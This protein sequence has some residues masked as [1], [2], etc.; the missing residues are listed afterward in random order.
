M[1]RDANTETF[2]EIETSINRLQALTAQ[3]VE[4][5]QRNLHCENPAVE[6]RTAQIVLDTSINGLAKLNE[7]KRLEKKDASDWFN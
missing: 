1:K 3:A 5:L 6:I 7:L 4:T 2:K